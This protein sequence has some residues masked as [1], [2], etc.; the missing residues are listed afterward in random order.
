MIIPV[1]ED[2]HLIEILHQ[3]VHHLTTGKQH[4]RLTEVQ[5]HHLQEV[6][7]HP[8]EVQA[9]KVQVQEVQVAGRHRKEEINITF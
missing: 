3:E 9:Q 5:D 4:P 8:L 7:V 6:A 2:L 1:Q